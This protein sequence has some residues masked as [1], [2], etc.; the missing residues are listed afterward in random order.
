MVQIS[1][2]E[3]DAA[4]TGKHPTAKVTLPS[5]PIEDIHADREVL[6][7]CCPVEQPAK[8]PTGGYVG[9]RSPGA[10]GC[11]DAGLRIDRWTFVPATVTG[12]MLPRP[13]RATTEVRQ[14]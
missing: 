13:S 9:L 4:S 7:R 10:L 14:W 1:D 3:P 2:I 5:E 8:G 12:G 6:S 11:V